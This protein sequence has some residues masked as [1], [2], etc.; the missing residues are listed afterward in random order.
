MGERSFIAN[1][2]DDSGNEDYLYCTEMMDD[3]NSH[4][5]LDNDSEFR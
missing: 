4:D 2:V 3:S 5:E 1:S